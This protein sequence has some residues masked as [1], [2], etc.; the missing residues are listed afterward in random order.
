MSTWAGEMST[1]FYQIWVKW[2]VLECMSKPMSTGAVKWAPAE[3]QNEQSDRHWAQCKK[4]LKNRRIWLSVL[5]TYSNC[6]CQSKIKIYNKCDL[7]IWFILDKCLYDWKLQSAPGFSYCVTYH[8]TLD[9]WVLSFYTTPIRLYLQSCTTN[10]KHYMNLLNEHGVL[11]D[12]RV[13]WAVHE[14]MSLLHEHGVLPRYEWNE[15]MSTWAGELSTE[16]YKI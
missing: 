13:K 12:M 4:E 6:I 11:Q 2:A 16:V 14:Y 1:G 7:S 8:F 3:L 10:A 5:M 15:Q 9:V